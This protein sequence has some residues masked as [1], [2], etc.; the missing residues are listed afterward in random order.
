VV[1]LA[2]ERSAVTKEVMVIRVLRSGVAAGVI[3]ALSV[4]VAGLG[5]ATAAN[6]GSLILGQSNSATSTTSLTDRHGTP[7]SLIGSH[8]KPPLSVNSSKRVA[9][10]N[11]SLLGGQPARALATNGS[12]VQTPWL[13]VLKVFRA[14]S[15]DP[16]AATEVAS[17]G[18]LTPGTYY[19]S[20]SV[21]AFNKGLATDATTCFVGPDANEN[22]AH[23]VTSESTGN[24]ESLSLDAVTKIGTAHKVAVN[25]FGPDSSI[26]TGTIFAIKIAHAVKG[27]LPKPT[28]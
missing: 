14:I 19:L 8:S 3:G 10:L 6:G 25:C 9:H 15:T 13:N 24:A 7:L 20:A 18:R 26:N 5:V 16:T 4:T 11:A 17:T 23:Q 21:N 1:I 28:F 27:S 12:G 22:D 2:G